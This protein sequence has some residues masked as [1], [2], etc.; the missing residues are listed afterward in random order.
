M[1]AVGTRYSQSPSPPSDGRRTAKMNSPRVLLHVPHSLGSHHHFERQR[2]PL[3]SLLD[4]QPPPPPPPLRP[5]SPRRSIAVAVAGRESPPPLDRSPRPG[6]VGAP[7]DGGDRG[8]LGARRRHAA[9]LRA[10][11][12]RRP[13]GAARAAARGFLLPHR[14]RARQHRAYS[15]LP[16]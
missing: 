6:W 13:V 2:P 12:R 4:T 11:R 5:V 14:R 16:T 1:S 7:S 9:G 15:N 8:A 10:A 3:S